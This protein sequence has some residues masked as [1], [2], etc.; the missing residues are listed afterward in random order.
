M[1]QHHAVSWCFCATCFLENHLCLQTLLT[2]LGGWLHARRALVCHHTCQTLNWHNNFSSSE[3][4]QTRL[5]Y[6]HTDLQLTDAVY[7]HRFLS[8]RCELPFGN[9]PNGMKTLREPTLLDDAPQRHYTWWNGSPAAGRGSGRHC[10]RNRVPPESCN[11]RLSIKQGTQCV[12]SNRQVDASFKYIHRWINRDIPTV[13]SLN[14]PSY[15]LEPKCHFG[16][17]SSF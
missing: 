6:I 15:A 5:P 3:A 16:R 14:K 2:A 9:Q 11:K 7:T 17:A 4:Q 8:V 13:S 10:C 12:L 1:L